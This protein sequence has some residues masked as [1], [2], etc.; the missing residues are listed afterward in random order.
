MDLFCKLNV[1]LNYSCAIT[2]KQC[3]LQYD[4]VQVGKIYGKAITT[5]QTFFLTQT[6]IV[7]LLRPLLVLIKKHVVVLG[8]TM[9]EF[10]GFWQQEK[11]E[12]LLAYPSVREKF[13]KHISIKWTRD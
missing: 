11:P 13:A 9:K 8:E 2:V 5:N 1:Q 3:V 6:C 4:Y 10:D 7:G 12:N